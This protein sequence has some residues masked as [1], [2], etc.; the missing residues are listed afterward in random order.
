M[1]F[2]ANLAKHPFSHHDSSNF[3]IPLLP[4]KLVSSMRH[5]KCILCNK[6]YDYEYFHSEKWQTNK[7]MPSDFSI[8]HLYPGASASC[9]S[10][11]ITWL[12]MKCASYCFSWASHHFFFQLAHICAV[13]TIIMIAILII[14]SSLSLLSLHHCDC[15]CRLSCGWLVDALR[16]MSSMLLLMLSLEELI[17]F[18]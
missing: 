1:Y 8:Y 9:H 14:S 4:F 5:G 13:M 7:Q 2:C 12:I 16:P 3:F 6:S 17:S 15:C 10:Y 18:E 11:H